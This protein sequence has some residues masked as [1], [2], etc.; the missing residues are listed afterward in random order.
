MA[1]IEDLMV[2][3]VVTAGGGE[4]VAA[5]SERMTKA[6]VGAVVL[7]E[8]DDLVGIFTERDLLKRVVA[9]GRDPGATPVGEV[10]TRKVVSMQLPLSLR[11]CADALRSHG[12]RHL[13]VVEAKRLVGIVSARDFF[14][15]VASELESFIERSRYE[16]QLRD[17][18]DP[19]DHFGGSYGR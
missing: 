2:R 9:E 3:D 13:P 10:A 6:S 8:G 18:V 4:T 16:E 5:V 1:S 14:Q 12:V 19:Y 17:N 15:A 11:D 7:V